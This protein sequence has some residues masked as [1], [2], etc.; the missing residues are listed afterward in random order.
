[1]KIVVLRGG[2]P[3]RRR[4][5]L[6]AGTRDRGVLALG[7]GTGQ[8]VLLNI[9]AA[10]A[11]Q[12]DTDPALDVHAGLGDAARRSVVL[13]D[14]QVDHVGGLLGLRDGAPVELYATPAVFESLTCTLPV[15]P[16]LQHYCGMHW[17]VVPVAGDR[18]EAQFQIE[19][20][21]TLEFTAIAV[22]APALPH[23]AEHPRI[24]DSIALAVRDLATGQRLFCAPGPAATGGLA[25]DWMREAD[26]VLVDGPEG[27]PPDPLWIDQLR[28]LPAS[29]KVLFAADAR[30]EQRAALDGSGIALAYD[31]MEIVL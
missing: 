22:S 10:V 31:R 11:H 24:G 21:P 13:T 1:M 9:S 8:W 6:R 14:A 17:H 12:L 29:R 15:L 19:S 7:S 30:G 28:G 26:C 25:Y 16:V 23:A 4:P 27:D 18:R 20:M 3:L 2:G 5:V